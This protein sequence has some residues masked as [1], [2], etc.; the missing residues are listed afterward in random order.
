MR[1]L[2]VI[3]GGIAAI[4]AFEVVKLLKAG[5]GA[6]TCVLTRAAKEFVTELS[7]AAYTGEKVY[8]DL[9][10]PEDESAMGHIGLSRAADVVLVA[11]ASADFIAKIANGFADDLAS[12]CL[13][14]NDGKPV[15]IAPAMNAKMY[16]YFAVRKNIQAL[17]D[18]GFHLI[19]PVTGETACG[20]V[21][22]GRMSSSEA[23]ADAVLSGGYAGGGGSLAGKRVLVTAGPTEE[24]IDP[25]RYISN[26]SS[27]RQGYA[28]A[29]ALVKNGADVTLVSGPV[30][31]PPPP[32]LRRIFVRTA[33]EM[34]DAVFAAFPF[35]AAL[36]VAAVSDWRADYTDQKLK[37]TERR[38]KLTLDFSKN[39]DI[40]AELCAAP[41][42]PKVIYGFCAETENLYVNA[43]EKLK[44]KRCDAIYAN[45][46]TS[47][48]GGVFGSERNRV[49][50][51]DNRF[52]AEKL[53]VYEGDKMEI[54]QK[55]IRDLIADL[56]AA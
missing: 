15:Y 31:L 29:E 22:E 20:E 54:A 45:P 27:G 41:Q 36:C 19:G 34:R 10:N 40:L 18:N 33:C 3:T 8:G 43:Q 48:E 7:L 56:A 25:V 16:A 55:I 2:Y 47:G 35:D 46:V 11:P 9:F 44:R 28:I 26:R 32:G 13:L 17:R 4:K 49:T 42:R 23:I 52:D 24:P 12:A 38:E 37:K 50:R 1:V 6:V 5:G 21:G 39:P 30:A 14:A 51:I 53:S